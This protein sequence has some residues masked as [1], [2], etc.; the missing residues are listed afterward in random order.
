MSD[1]AALIT[2]IGGILIG[3]LSALGVRWR[4]RRT[5]ARAAEREDADTNLVRAEAAAKVAAA[6]AST[7]ETMQTAARA[8]VETLRRQ[9]LD[10]SKGLRQLVDMGRELAELEIGR[11]RAELEAAVRAQQ[12]AEADCHA[13]ITLIR[14]ELEARRA[15]AADEDADG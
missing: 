11:L 15:L 5:A 6:A 3:L 9:T 4:D 1:L 7:V 10:A 14:A 12:A 8:E 13:E 2:A